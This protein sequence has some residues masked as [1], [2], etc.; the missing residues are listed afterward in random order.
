MTFIHWTVG[1]L[2]AGS[3]FLGL[4]LPS[5]E[6]STVQLIAMLIVMASVPASSSRR[7]M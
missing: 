6:S 1:I 5:D 7:R 3:G 4:I 2:T